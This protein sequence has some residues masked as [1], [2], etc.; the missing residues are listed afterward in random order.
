MEESPNSAFVRDR[1]V[2][3]G[4]SWNVVKEDV[5]FSPVHMQEIFH[6]SA[7]EGAANYGC[8]SN[9]SEEGTEHGRGEA[10]IVIGG[11]IG[12]LGAEP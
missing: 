7:V 10:D 6:V 3:I 2:K 5:T 8:L 12:R 11:C 4:N 1:A 9:A